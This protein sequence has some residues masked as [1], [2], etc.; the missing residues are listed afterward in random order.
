MEIEGGFVTHVSGLE[1]V[2]RSE[3]GKKRQ[4]I[5]GDYS[6]DISESTGGSGA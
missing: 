1:G 3:N 6:G 4:V 2:L 5:S